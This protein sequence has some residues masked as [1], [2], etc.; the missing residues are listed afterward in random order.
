MTAG[1]WSRLLTVAAGILVFSSIA[2]A[3][4]KIAIVN[5]NSAIAQTAQIK[6]ENA[7]LEAKYRPQ[8]QKIEALGKEL[9]ALQTK[10]QQGQN[11]LS[12]QAYQELVQDGQRKQTQLQRMQE[13]LQTDFNRDRQEVLD[14]IG[15]QML[16]VIH[17]IAQEK[18]LDMVV[19]VFLSRTY[20]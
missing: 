1:R 13:D 19:D 11:T 18:D 2:L 7:R 16:D 17:K 8:Q 12:A 10:L 20:R 15:R 5:L 6:V 4:T 14:R 9:Q 3:Q